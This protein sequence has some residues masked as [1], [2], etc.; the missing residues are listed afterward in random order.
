M[1]AV[2]VIRFNLSL[3]SDVCGNL[4]YLL[5]GDTG[6]DDGICVGASDG[7]SLG[8]DK[9]DRMRVTEVHGQ[10]VSAD[11]CSV[12]DTGDNQ[13]FA[14]RSYDALHHVGDEHSVKTVHGLGFFKFVVTFD[15]DDVSVHLDVDCVR[16]DFLG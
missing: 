12:T 4:S 11:R 7:N 5:F 8:S 1:Q 14:E 15:G 10:F 6:Y 2:S 3:G 9:L 13:R 16:F